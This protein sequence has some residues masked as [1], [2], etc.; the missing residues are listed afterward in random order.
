MQQS[1]L[2]FSFVSL[3][4]C[5]LTFTG[6]GS[7]DGFARV[8][9]KGSVTVDGK[10]L[11]EGVIRFIPDKGLQ[12][13]TVQA[14][15]QNGEYALDD[16]SGPVAGKHRVEI[17]ATGYLGFEL[18]DDLAYANYIKTH[19]ALPP[20]PIPPQFN[21]ESKLTVDIPAAGQEGLDFRLP[22]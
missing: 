9:V 22:K 1:F 17:E 15:V 7:S 5:G 10:P 13:Q 19:G 14:V 16:R 6:C 11:A 2:L 3:C 18:D 12:G 8:P 20:N 4:L 21:R